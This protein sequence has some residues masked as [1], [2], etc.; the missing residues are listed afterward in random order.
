MGKSLI[1]FGA[2]I[3]LLG[4]IVSVAS[5]LG[6]GHLPGDI[7]IKRKSFSLYIP[8]AS[9]ILISVVLTLL[10]NLFRRR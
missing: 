1:I 4:V 5:R 9:S 6:L 7:L 2:A 10:L 3:V 8:V